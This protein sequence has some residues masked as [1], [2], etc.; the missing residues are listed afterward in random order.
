MEIRDRIKEVRNAI[1][2]TQAKFAERIAISTSYISELEKGLKDATER[3]L[4]LI[5][6]EFNVSEHWLK[7]GQGVMF[8]EDVSANVSEAIGM[9]KSLDPPFQKG[10]LKILSALEEINENIRHGNISEAK[11]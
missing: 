2:I 10:V 7:T 8:N 4:R 9:F 6:S 5:A 11:L 3:I 1:G